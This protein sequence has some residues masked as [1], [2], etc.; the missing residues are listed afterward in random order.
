MLDISPKIGSRVLV[1][2][3]GFTAFDCARS[4]LR[5][6]AEEVFIC[7][8]RTEEDLSV[9]HDEVMET[10]KEG[11][12]ILS[13]MLSGKIIG[14]SH[15][16]GIEF[17][18]TKPGDK[19]SDGKRSVSPIEGSEF[20]MPA[21]TVIV[22]AGQRPGP[23]ELPANVEVIKTDGAKTDYNTSIKGLYVAGDFMTGPS[24][25]IESIAM[26]RDAACRIAHDLTGTPIYEKAIRM[27]EVGTTDRQ[28]AWDFLPRQEMPTILPVDKRIQ[29][30][31]LE[32]ETGHP[33]DAA[34]QASRRC[35]LCYLHYEIDM[36]RCI[37]C[38]YCIDVAPRDC[39][40]LVNAITI[41]DDGAVTGYEET[42]VWQDVNAVIIDNSRCIR[43]GE[44]LR[45]CPVECISVTKVELI[46]KPAG[47][48]NG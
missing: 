38:R 18:R 23:F 33:P 19:R 16:T 45:V 46:D 36:G 34:I 17:V 6:G 15:V 4:A 8:R 26:G 22:A 28:R 27:E 9:A 39:I 48:L 25:V 41:N 42:T 21:D 2:G 5:L 47:E 13:L 10:K 1:I 37:Y 3:A 43:C 32:V 11:V 24:T 30:P 12:K 40:K 29:H 7:L 31:S 14:D 20:F 35:Y 44:C